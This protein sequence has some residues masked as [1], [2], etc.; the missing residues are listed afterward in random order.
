MSEMAD[1]DPT[2]PESG[3]EREALLRLDL[4]DDEQADAHLLIHSSPHDEFA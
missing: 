1:P 2:D 4:L 3:A